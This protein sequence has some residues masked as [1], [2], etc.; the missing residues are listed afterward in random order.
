MRPEANMQAKKKSRPS[1]NWRQV[2]AKGLQAQQPHA[3]LI[4]I[5]KREDRERAIVAFL[6]VPWTSCR[7]RDN[8]FLVTRD[9]V[10]ALKQAGIPFEDISDPE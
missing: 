2:S 7:F 10:R 9:H 3:F 6:D 5:S 8:Q 1:P 4:R